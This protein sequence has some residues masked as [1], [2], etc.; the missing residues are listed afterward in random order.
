MTVRSIRRP[1]IATALV[2]AAATLAFTQSASAS[3]PLPAAARANDAGPATIAIGGTGKIEANGAAAIVPVTVTCTK[4]IEFD[5]TVKVAQAVG[6]TMRAG[7]TVRRVT[8]VEGAQ[9]VR[10]AVIPVERSFAAGV[11]FGVLDANPCDP[12]CIPI[13]NERQF[14]LAP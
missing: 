6:Q 4:A 7:T 14:T 2:A 10:I 5:L 11:A 9:Q 1:L 8:C 12:Y 13:F 3:I